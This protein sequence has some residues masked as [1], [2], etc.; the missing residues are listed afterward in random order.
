MATVYFTTT[1]WLR[2]NT[3][4]GN[5]V[6]ENV[7]TPLVK[8]AADMFPRS[9]LGTYFYNHLLSA[10]N[11]QTLNP[12]ETTL[13]SDYLKPA[14]GWRTAADV[15]ANSSLLLRN[16][17]VQT[18]SG[19]FSTSA[20]FSAMSFLQRTNLE[21]AEFYDNRLF[22]YLVKNKNLFPQFLDEQNQD[23][24]ARSACGSCNCGHSS[25]LGTS[26]CS[27]FCNPSLSGF[28]SNVIFI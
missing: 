7:I 11:A 18:Q 2:N 24:T 12:D 5:S 25:C 23:S 9:I 6:D 27:G 15:A 19:D 10:Y 21:K 26:D 13:V 3:N 4:I 16:K 17:G 14:I 1:Q 22:T 28:Y 8:T 20:E